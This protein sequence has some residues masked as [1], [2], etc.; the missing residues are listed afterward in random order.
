MLRLVS[1]TILHRHGSRGPGESELSPFSHDNPIHSQWKESEIEMLSSTGHS[2]IEV[3]GAWF[4]NRYVLS[5]LV[6]ISSGGTHWRSSKSDRAKES[7][8]DFVRGFNNAIGVEAVGPEPLSYDVDADNYFR[9]WKVFEKEAAVLKNKPCTDEIWRAKAEENADFLTEVFTAVDALP[10]VLSRHPQALWCT[11]YLY[12]LKQCEIFWPKEEGDRREIS[13]RLSDQ[14]H[15]K[16]TELALWVW[17]QRFLYSSFTEEMGGRIAVELLD[18]AISRNIALGIFSG[19]DYTILGVLAALGVV[20]R[21]K[22]ATGFGSYI[23]FELWESCEGSDSSAD[24]VLKVIFNPDPFRS[25]DLRVDVTRVNEGNE[26]VLS[27]AP[28]SHILPSLQLLRERVETF[29]IKKAKSQKKRFWGPVGLFWAK[30][31]ISSRGE[32]EL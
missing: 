31:F 10:T 19:H 8:Y 17:E 3:L 25:T 24:P 20:D 27:E 32:V 12:A 16:V 29:P 9:P 22:H 4:A 7:A 18:C 1:S 2:Q 5:G 21:F 23:I 14:A 11:T 30:R 26:M 13:R 15:A 28:L 6:D